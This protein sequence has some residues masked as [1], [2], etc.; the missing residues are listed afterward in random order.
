MILSKFTVI[1]GVQRYRAITQC[2]LM[3][4]SIDTIPVS[5]AVEEVL[6]SVPNDNAAP[7]KKRGRPKK[8]VSNTIEVKS[9]WVP[10]ALIGIC[11]NITGYKFILCIY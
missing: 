2:E 5:V 7:K 10:C 8:V 3:K 4:S 9:D 1:V 11:F 6:N